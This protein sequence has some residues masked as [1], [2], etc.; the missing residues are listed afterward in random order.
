MSFFSHFRR[1]AEGA[2]KLAPAR[3]AFANG[4][5]GAVATVA[6]LAAAH[7]IGIAEP[8]LIGLAGFGTAI[9]DKG[10][11]YRARATAM[12]SFAVLGSLSAIVGAAA[13]HTK[14]SAIVVSFFWI[15][16]C[17]MIRVYGPAAAS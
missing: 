5:R 4:I 11:S 9:V 12:T 16:L 17:A 1:H 3:P 14:V 7:F 6:P 2:A 13:A 15:A 8:G 10:G